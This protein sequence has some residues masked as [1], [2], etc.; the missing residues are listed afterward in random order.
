MIGPTL[1]PWPFLRLPSAIVHAPGDARPPLTTTIASST[2]MPIANT[3]PNNRK[4]VEAEPHP[5]HDRKRADDRH[6]HGDQW[7]QGCA[8]R[9]CK[10][11][12]TTIA[13]RIMASRR[14]LK[15]S[16]IDFLNERRGVIDDCVVHVGRKAAFQ[17][18]HS[19]S[20]AGRGVSSAFDPGCWKMPRPMDGLPSRLHDVSSFLAPN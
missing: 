16:L 5:Q 3:R 1:R 17:F 8:R 19:P 14:A 13:T 6:G 12:R 9:L 7:Y 10:N 4:V 11:A 18:L 20:N 2:T 15:T